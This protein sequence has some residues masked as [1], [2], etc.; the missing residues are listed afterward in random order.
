M[1]QL[2]LRDM[3]DRQIGYKYPYDHTPLRFHPQ[4]RASLAASFQNWRADMADLAWL[5]EDL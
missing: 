1:L 4:P 5:E 3:L 2:S